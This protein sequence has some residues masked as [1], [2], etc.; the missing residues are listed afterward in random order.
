MT[1]QILSSE[2]SVLIQESKRKNAELRTAA[3]ESLEQLKS[4]H[5][6][7]ETQLA[8]DLQRR[9]AFVTPFLV[10]CDSRNTRF[11]S[12]GVSCLQKL[13]VSR[14]LAG[15][16]LKDVLESLRTA[17]AQGLDVQLKI[18]QALPPLTQ[19][20][21][22]DLGG[23][24]LGSAL[25]VCSTLQTSK[26]PVVSSTATA[27]FQQLVTSVFDRVGREDEQELDNDH[28]QDLLLSGAHIRARPAALD[29]YK[30]FNDVCS[31]TN[32]Q[33]PALLRSA[34][35]AQT[36]GLEL[37][38]S[39]LN[40]HAE[41]FS[42]HAELV[43]VLRE[44]I[45]PL[46]IQA[47][48]D[49]LGFAVT[50][51]VM[52]ILLLV[53]QDHLQAVAAQG[54][55]ALGILIHLLDP[56][57][58][59][60]WKRVLCMELLRA[61]HADGNLVRTIY[62]LYDDQAGKKDIVGRHV[63]ALVRLTTEKPS[64][65]GLGGQSTA[66]RGDASSRTTSD[67][68]AAMDAGAVAGMIG[69]AVSMQGSSL[70]GISAQWSSARSPLIDQLDKVDPPDMPE[71]YL[72]SL[73]L[74][75]I[76]GFSEGLAKFILPLAVL[77][78]TRTRK[79][80]PLRTIAAAVEMGRSPPPSQTNEIINTAP[81][82]AT[83]K[84]ESVPNPLLLQSHPMSGEIRICTAI[85][86][87][88]WPAI[89]ATCST[90]LV[91]ALDND[92]FHSLIRS[93]QKFTQVSGL[94]ELHTPRDAFMT[95][96]GKAA[97]PPKLVSGNLVASP[98]S[99]GG[100]RQS[101]IQHP[102]AILAT[103]H[104]MP[105]ASVSSG[106]NRALPVPDVGSSLNTRNLLCLR[107]LV[108][109]AIALGPTL[110][111]A[112]TIVLE[113]LQQAEYIMH[114]TNHNR[115][116][117]RQE[118]GGD[119]ATGSS[120]GSTTAHL[121]PEIRAL[122]S[123]ATRML[124][125]SATFSNDSFADLL[126]ACRQLLSVAAL[127]MMTD[128]L[129]QTQAGHVVTAPNHT[130]SRASS[131]SEVSTRLP[132][133]VEKD[134]FA[135]LKLGELASVNTVRLAEQNPEASGWKMLV[136]T[137]VSVAGSQHLGVTERSTAV[138]NL[139]SMVLDAFKLTSPTD[140]SD[141]GLVQ[142]RLFFTIRASVESL[143]PPKRNGSTAPSGADIEIH[144]M[145]LETLRSMLEHG[146]EGLDSGWDDIFSVMM[147]A[148]IDST[149]PC[150]ENTTS[151]S[152]DGP[153]SCLLKPRASSLLRASFD[154]LQLVCSDFLSCIPT[155]AFPALINALYAF[156]FQ[157][158]ELNISLTALYQ[159]D[160]AARDETTILIVNGITGL[161]ADFYTVLTAT[162][163]FETSWRR[164]ICYLQVL[165]ARGSLEIKANVYRALVQVL[166]RAKASNGWTASSTK[167]VWELWAS[168][169]PSDDIKDT[170]RASADQDAFEAYVHLS[171][172][173]YRLM[174]GMSDKDVEV[175]VARLLDCITSSSR[176]PY[177]ADVDQPTLLQKTTLE[178]MASIERRTPRI[179]AIII[180]SLAKILRLPYQTDRRQKGLTY[181]ALCRI[182]MTS[183]QTLTLQDRDERDTFRSH[184]FHSALEALA[185]PIAQRFSGQNAD[186][187]LPRWRKATETCLTILESA[188]PALQKPKLAQD[189]AQR[190]WKCVVQITNAVTES[191]ADVT[192]S[193]T[194]DADEA[195]DIEAS[196]RL[197][198]LLIPQ[199]GAE[200]VPDIVR[201]EYAQGLFCNSFVHRAEVWDLPGPGRQLAS[202]IDTMYQIR[203]GRT[204]EPPKV[205]RSQMSY[206]CLDEL[207]RLAARQDGSMERVR[208]A[209]AASPYLIVRA[210]TILRAY[211]ADQPLRG[212]MP[213][214]VS[215]RRELIYILDHLLSLRGEPR[216]IP[217]AP[218]AQSESKKHLQ[219]L[220]PLMGKA[221]RVAWNDQEV[222]ELLGQAM[223]DVSDE[224]GFSAE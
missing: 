106:K 208:L 16:K 103:E 215:Q 137:F 175:T 54:E 79:K 110:G 170:A 209:Q 178:A 164:F 51:R 185:L 131:I 189:E 159:K 128:G 219:R 86:D 134:Y 97:V 167:L 118:Q 23:E 67:E 55:V 61:I 95:T 221:T 85:M 69:G 42:S 144:Q 60:T 73:A 146:G 149:S 138:Q 223:D 8:A 200:C 156:S 111:R 130:H 190:F 90:F 25:L 186:R 187:D 203:M 100:I 176:P 33:K 140:S 172:Q 32:G 59:P 38:E 58:A 92:L 17:T 88:C 41:L 117:L 10:A 162:T 161:F 53:V 212:Q 169:L 47:L 28:A 216:A 197:R 194:A 45:M 37:I 43:H 31:L 177:T 183:L 188:L 49:Q 102:R 12:I 71:T 153:F 141:R 204:Y 5:A 39:V 163:E 217:D 148:F 11:I 4:L 19:N 114:S 21:A 135:L 139:N 214:P 29:A 66:P 13:I 104:T 157:G 127:E 192:E 113:T 105:S 191:Q 68:Q 99:P 96:L 115:E 168:A 171:G 108:N 224:M 20:Y 166:M 107:A 9:P 65:I 89:L 120:A 160:Q 165:L 125:S 7:S 136:E 62:A 64:V 48:S 198:G 50:V 18:L 222:L 78:E 145:I 15:E 124:E 174:R 40:N 24:K 56:E 205:T 152:P 34:V 122:E 44:R 116:R 87:N 74:T 52:R 210:A 46:I 195:F 70:T 184:A 143:C 6:T 196:R 72:Y 180:E 199:L 80:R 207:F 22:D 213:Q 76:N 150:T 36:F 2:L 132:Y 182:A 77:N 173:L 121:G 220:M 158:V 179:R 154:S 98:T 81:V 82:G 63:A 181:I 142:Q 218:N 30:V 27:T 35:I 84:P 83:A 126:E 3:E 151:A 94:L 119:D 206:V 57:N 75:C 123:A 1:A 112:W 202:S 133:Q 193:T 129:L 93:I 109:L 211:I 14:C 201:R 101:S 91:A 147:S 26:F 155:P